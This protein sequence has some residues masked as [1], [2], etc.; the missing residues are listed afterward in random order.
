MNDADRDLLNSCLEAGWI[1]EERRQE[2]QKALETSKEMSFLDFVSKKKYLNEEQIA[3]LKDL[4]LHAQEAPPAYHPTVSVSEA[5]HY[6]H[7]GD[8]LSYAAQTSC[9][10]LHLTSGAP[11]LLRLHGQLIPIAEGVP[12]LHAEDVKK[13]LRDFLTPDQMKKVEQ[14]S[15]LD[16]CHEME[17]V[18]RFRI[19]VMRHRAG[20]GAAFRVIRSQVPHI[21]DLGLP[22][23]VYNLA[24]HHHGLIL[25]TGTTGSGKSTT[26]AALIQY[27]SQTRRDHIVTLEDPIE[28]VFPIGL[29]QISQREMGSHSRSFAT[30]LRAALREDP[31]VIMVG[32]MRDLETISLAIM[33]AETGHLVL[34]TLHTSTAARTLDRLLD[35]FPAEQRA[36]V[37]TSVSE[38]L[39]GI[40]CQQ[41]IPKSD[42]TGRVLA[43]EV[44][45][46]TSAVANLIRE[47]KTFM[48]PGVIQTEKRLGMK[49]MDES[50]KEL[51]D[52]RVI[53]A[54]EAWHRIE[55]KNIFNLTVHV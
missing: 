13:L 46:N 23:V 3:T 29:C 19:N 17:H 14:E 37:R 40:I 30:A 38:S 1:T 31:D 42:G 5:A 25:I 2:V 33:A 21:E 34:S 26:L 50:I 52:A 39:K 32:E 41:L 22:S 45:L 36:Q 43:T 35:V 6:K 10:D 7:I 4:L 20:W 28:Y 27:I 9:S 55:N 53:T 48:I 15:S 47:G 24:H 51:F 12:A 54:L 16:F 49:L 18:G 11:P 8:Y 44:L